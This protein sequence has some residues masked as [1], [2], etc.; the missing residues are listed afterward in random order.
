MDN[1]TLASCSY[2]TPNVTITML[3]SFF[4]HHDQTFVLICDNST[5]NETKI[6]L[7]QNNIPYLSN[8]GSLHS[9]SVDFLI[10]NC[11]TDYMLLVDTDI[12]FLK[13]HEDIYNQFVEM[14]LTLLGEICGDRGGKKLHNRVHPWHC[15]INVKNIKKHNVKFHD[16]NRLSKKINKKVYDVGASF[17]EDIH[18]QNLKIGNIKLQD[19]YYRHYEGMSWRTLK[20]GKKDENIDINEAA[21]HNNIEL[22]RYGR[23][24]EQ[25]YQNEI[26]TYKDI[27]I[28]AI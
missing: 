25:M 28:K 19:K 11:K 12:I 1:L 20:Y 2:N 15:F 4:K 7:E 14:E 6:L 22:Y 21:T 8:K 24:V 18:K 16:I 13:S 10:E 26:K 5:N 17:F 3:R 23:A 27:Q 9:P